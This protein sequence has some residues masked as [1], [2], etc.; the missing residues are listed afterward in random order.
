[1]TRKIYEGNNYVYFTEIHT[2]QSQSQDFP[3][4]G[5]PFRVK[6]HVDVIQW[7]GGGVAAEIFRDLQKPMRFSGAIRWEGG[8]WSPFR[9]FKS[10]K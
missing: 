9:F 3:K 10:K 5:A 1:M 7:E 8:E 4:E 6:C 2:V